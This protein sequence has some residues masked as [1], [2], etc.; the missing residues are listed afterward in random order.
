MA[1]DG[2]VVM[3]GDMWFTVGALATVDKA[4]PRT[5]VAKLCSLFGSY[6]LAD[7]VRRLWCQIYEEPMGRIDFRL[8]PV[9]DLTRP[10]GT[11][12]HGNRL[13]SLVNLVRGELQSACG[14]PSVTTAGENGRL[15]FAWH[16]HNRLHRGANLPARVTYAKRG[17]VSCKEWYVDGEISRDGDQ[18]ARICYRDGAVCAK[19]WYLNG[20][21]YR[22][23]DK[24]P[25]RSFFYE[26]GTRR[27]EVWDDPSQP[28]VRR[29]DYNADGTVANDT[30]VPV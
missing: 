9:P 12:R 2:L 8:L 11:I 13:V 18:P 28:S 24:N 26:D 27:R 5:Y 17:A 30:G 15:E 1:R 6:S 14:D 29:I 16:R 4:E 3:T 20:E 19:Y 7:V 21:P 10:T 25:T 23:D 22:V